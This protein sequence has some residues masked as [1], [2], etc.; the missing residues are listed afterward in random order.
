MVIFALF[1][2]IKNTKTMYFLSKVACQNV[3]FPDVFS[4]MMF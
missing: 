1:Y 3:S 4:L 2:V